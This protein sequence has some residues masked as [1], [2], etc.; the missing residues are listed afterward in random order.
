[1][2]KI[3]IINR[4][5]YDKKNKRHAA[6]IVNKLKEMDADI[7]FTEY[8]GHAEKI[9][10]NSGAYDIII[11]GGGDGSISEIVNGMDLESQALGIIPMGTGNSL[12]TDLK[13][14]GIGKSF[15]VIKRSGIKKI[16]LLKCRF[17]SR[18]S[19][20]EKY[21]VTTSGIGLGEK[22][23]SFGNH[24]LK[25]LGPL[26]YIVAM[27]IKSFFQ[28]TLSAE[29]KID[30]SVTESTEFTSFFANNTKHAGNVRIF[31]AAS[32]DDSKLDFSF[33]RRNF[34]TQYLWNTG[35]LTGTY[36]YYPAAKTAGKLEIGLHKAA[37]LMLDG[38]MFESVKEIIYSVIP[39]KLSVL[40]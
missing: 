20:F 6:L 31:P 40:N 8:R 7:I 37:A 28:E 11:A 26:C 18:G 33:A 22:T 9:A 15:D 1:M 5:C 10:K 17:E 25:G 21:L 3:A 27:C 38:E 16:D 35:V 14:S 12:A 19:E 30:G 29:I 34:F 36:I 2:K 4:V 39:K 24:Y 32:L 13:I 23:A